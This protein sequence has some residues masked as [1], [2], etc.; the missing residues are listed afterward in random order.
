MK[1]QIGGRVGREGGGG[2][3]GFGEISGNTQMLES[4][5]AHLLPHSGFCPQNVLV[6]QAPSADRPPGF[7]SPEH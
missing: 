7:Y 2:G 1:G 6:G 5:H 4:G 3:G